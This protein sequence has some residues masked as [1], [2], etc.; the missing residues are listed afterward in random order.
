MANVAFLWKFLNS[1]FINNKNNVVWYYAVQLATA[2]QQ[3]ITI[4]RMPQKKPAITQWL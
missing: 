4:S 2:I 1:V 3:Y